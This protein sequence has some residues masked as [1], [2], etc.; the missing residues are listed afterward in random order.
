M[1]IA[2]T[3]PTATH[4]KLEMEL[5]LRNKEMLAVMALRHKVR[6]VTLPQTANRSKS[7]TLPTNKDSCL[8]DPTSQLRPLFQKK[9]KKPSIKTWPT[10]LAASSMTDNINLDQ[11]KAVVQAAPVA[12]QVESAVVREELAAAQV[13]AVQVVSAV[14]LVV[15]VVL[16]A[17]LVVLQVVLAVGQVVV[18][19]VVSA[20][21]LVVL[22]VLQAE[23]VVLQVVLAAVQVVVVQVVS[24]A[25]QV[26]LEVYRSTE[27]QLPLHSDLVWAPDLAALVVT[28][29]NG[30]LL[31]AINYRDVIYY[32]K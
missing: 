15:L 13:L 25:V 9:S 26:E 6:S 2:A 7:N 22:V 24:A 5:M 30:I 29:T 8:K 14:A 11:M 28:G 27:P 12:A 4:T 3:V 32:C 18:D 10:K 19:Q 20:V 21:A 16:Q 17:V 23:L 1:S 31:L